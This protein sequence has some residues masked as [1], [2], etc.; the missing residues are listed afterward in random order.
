[1]KAIQT[2]ITN[3]SIIHIRKEICKDVECLQP[4]TKK[5]PANKSLSNKARFALMDIYDAATKF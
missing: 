1:M 3:D 4:Y 2:S 5:D